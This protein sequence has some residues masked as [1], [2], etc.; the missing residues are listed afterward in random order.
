MR[1]AVSDGRENIPCQY[2]STTAYYS[3]FKLG[4]LELI[5][6]FL[7]LTRSKR[8]VGTDSYQRQISQLTCSSLHFSMLEPQARSSKIE[9]EDHLEDPIRES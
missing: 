1:V 7:L 4:L 9:L 6:L 3:G 8:Q 2:L 5:H